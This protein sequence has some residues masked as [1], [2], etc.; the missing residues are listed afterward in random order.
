MSQADFE[1]LS[2]ENLGNVHIVSSASLPLDTAYL[3]LSH[4]WGNPPSL[5]LNQKTKYLLNNDIT[6]DLLACTEAAVFRHAIQVTR[7][8]GFRYIWIDALCIMQDDG[9]EKTAEIMQMDQIFFGCALNISATEAQILEGLIFDRGILKTNPCRT[10]VRIP[11]TLTDVR[12]QAVPDKCSLRSAEG[13]LNKRGWV[14]Q[15][16]TLAPR[17]VHFTKYQVFWECRSLEASEILPQGVPDDQIMRFEK[18]IETSATS[19]IQQV[20]SRW[21]NLVEVYSRTSLSFASDRLLA[22]SAVARRCCRGMRLDYTDYLAGMFKDDLP[23][24]M[25]WAQDSHTNTAESGSESSSEIKIPDAPSWSW[26]SLLTPVSF[27]E[28]SGLNSTAGFL[29]VNVTRLSPDFFGGIV[30]C[31]LRLLGPICRIQRR[32]EDSNSRIYVGQHTV[33][34]EFQEFEFQEGRYIVFEWDASRRIVSDF[35]NTNNNTSA[36]STCV[37]L[38]IASENSEDGLQERGIILHKTASRGTYTRTGRFF[39]PFSSEYSG[40]ELEQAFKG[41]LNT[42]CRDDYLEQDQELSGKFI[43]DIE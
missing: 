31:R 26:A 20:K 11:G 12:L 27:V 36:A 6:T 5:L 1:M 30:S 15:E 35:L 33:F 43:I 32:I 14:F 7:G 23:L 39:I 42:L 19:T 13:P 34:D 28:L 21:Y 2:L 40:S 8:L 22:I 4:R 41:H 18:G 24:S 17:I 16:R 37:L 10:T 29:S 9:S 38:H 3:T 25:L